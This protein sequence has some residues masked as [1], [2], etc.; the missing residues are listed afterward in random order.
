MSHVTSRKLHRNSLFASLLALASF[1]VPMAGAQTSLQS[2]VAVT[3]LF[4]AQSTKTYFKI[5]VPAAQTRLEIRLSGPAGS[6]DCDLYV[7]FGV[8]PT[9]SSWD[10]RPYRSDSNETVTVNNPAAGD[11][12]IMLNGYTAFSSLSLVATI[13][14]PTGTAVAAPTFSPGSGTYTGEVIVSLAT[15]TTGAMIR[16]TTDGSDP[17]DLSQVYSAPLMISSSVT[18]KARGFMS[19][20]TTSGVATAAYTIVPS[21]AL[22]L[23]SGVAKT[24]LSGTVNS[25]A[26][27]KIFVP[28]GQTSLVIRITG[29]T[30]SGDCDLYVKQGAQPTLSTF[31][32]RPYLS[33]ANETVSVSSPIAGDWYIMLHGY[34]AY[35]GV[36]LVA[37][38]SASIDALP[39][40]VPVTSSLNARTSTE[41]FTAGACDALEGLVATGKRR[42]LRFTTET[43]NIGASD[44]VLRSPVNNPLFTYA[45]C[46]GHYHFNNFA[47]YRLLN[48]A[49]QQ[50]AVGQKV[51]FCLEDVSRWNPAANSQPQYNCDYQG[52]QAG[53]SDIYGGNLPG[54]WIDITGLAAGTYI[55]EINFD[56]ANRIAEANETNNLARVQVTIRTKDGQVTSSPLP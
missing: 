23:E 4:G 20:L 36:T 51:G 24:G 32:Y 43:R 48:T 34:T 7:K 47:E 5:N 52:I 14:G 38:F 11:W 6:G 29:A 46:H 49:G 45:P 1:L 26:F 54:Q 56:T 3:G 28:A 12:F 13:T 33:G 21:G 41:T 27:Y 19:G 37:T 40:L 30:N 17:T 31:D 42:L 50:V 15:A 18:V 53:W 10:Y 16:Y 55:L 22:A 2:G 25:Q 8:Q 35:S 39:D 44:L 9:L